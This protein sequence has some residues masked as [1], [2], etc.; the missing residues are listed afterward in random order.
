MLDAD[1]A[2]I[3][4]A[5]ALE[6]CVLGTAAGDMLGLPFE[7]LTRPQVAR[8]LRL[9]LEQSLLFGRGRVSDDTEHTA[10]L[11]RSLLEARDDPRRFARRFAARLRW[12]LLSAPPGVGGA[13]A[14]AAS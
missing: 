13:T 1:A 3:A 4:L 12:W 11:A 6:G 8:L 5:D 10:M 9:P 14:R 2:P 7:N